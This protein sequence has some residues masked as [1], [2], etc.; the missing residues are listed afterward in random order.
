MKLVEAQVACSVIVY[1]FP[2]RQSFA[3]LCLFRAI[4]QQT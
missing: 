4:G 1:I 2:I 3:S